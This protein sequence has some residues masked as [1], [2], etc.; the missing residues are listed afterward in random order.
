MYQGMNIVGTKEVIDKNLPTAIK[1]TIDAEVN[2]RDE[3][4]RMR[5]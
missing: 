2:K 3:N 1:R 5:K 4:S